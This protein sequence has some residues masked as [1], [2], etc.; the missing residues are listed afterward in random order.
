MSLEDGPRHC[1]AMWVAGYSEQRER[2]INSI[3]SICLTATGFVCWE[4]LHI[5]WTSKPEEAARHHLSKKFMFPPVLLKLWEFGFI[6]FYTTREV[7]FRAT[8]WSAL[9][10]YR[11]FLESLLKKSDSYYPRREM[12][13][14]PGV[15]L[16][17]L[18]P[19]W[20]CRG[21]YRSNGKEDQESTLK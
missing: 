2:N 20:L 17:P 12:L 5:Y 10:S 19:Q 8:F 16:L 3:Y 6:K 14:I 13:E 4:G 9:N 7:L 15:A 1:H 21:F 18:C 11:R